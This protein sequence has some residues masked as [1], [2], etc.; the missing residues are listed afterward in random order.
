MSIYSNQKE[1]E[2]WNGRE[3]WMKEG[4]NVIISFGRAAF[5]FTEGG[6]ALGKKPH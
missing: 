1:E 3:K 5:E 2:A 6:I 4:E